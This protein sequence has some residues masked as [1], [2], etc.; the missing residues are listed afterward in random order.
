MQLGRRAWPRFY[1][2]FMKLWKKHGTTPRYAASPTIAKP[3]SSR[4]H[5]RFASQHS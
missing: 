2:N 5:R 3:Q 1:E 4:G